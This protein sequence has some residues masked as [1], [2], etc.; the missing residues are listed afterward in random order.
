MRKP[1]LLLPCFLFFFFLILVSRAWAIN[2]AFFSL[3]PPDVLPRVGQT[4]NIDVTLNT[5]EANVKSVDA[6]LTF[7]PVKLSVVTLTPGAVF[8]SYPTKNF[9]TLGNIKLSGAMTSTTASFSG[10][11]KFGTITFK[12]VSSG[13]TNISFSCTPGEANDSNI[14]QILTDTDIVDCDKLSPTSISIAQAVG[15]PT[16]T[17]IA[18]ASPPPAG[19]TNPTFLFF[20]LSLG[21]LIIG[22]LKLW[23]TQNKYGQN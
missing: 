21:F 22:S 19:N 20:I 5:D 7:D 16:A 3:S 1:K 2:K 10:I 14:T 6:V 8:D 9:D 4:F 23:L 13:T 17:P 18:T 15:A 11:G 12:G